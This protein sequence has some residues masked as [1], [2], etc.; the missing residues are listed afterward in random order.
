MP[1]WQDV[2]RRAHGADG[3]FREQFDLDSKVRQPARRILSRSGQRSAGFTLV[4][5]LVAI[6]VL[7]IL[8]ALVIR[9]SAGAL[10]RAAGV[11]CVTNLRNLHAAFARY[12]QENGHW[13]QRPEALVESSNQ[14]ALEDWWIEEMT[15]YGGEEKVWQCPTLLRKIRAKDNPRPRIHYTPTPFDD[16]PFTPYKWSTQPWLAEVGNLHGRGAL[17]CFPDGSIR[18][19]DDFLANPNP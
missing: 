9:F 12:V 4:E 19:T 18:P 15:P 6:G 1:F 14:D 11:R 10:E 5:I 13:P 2:M 3:T 17:L 16:K 8:V 7:A